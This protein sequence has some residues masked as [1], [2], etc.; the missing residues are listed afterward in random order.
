MFGLTCVSARL[1]GIQSWRSMTT[2]SNKQGTLQIAGSA[3]LDRR[4]S[5][6]QFPPRTTRYFIS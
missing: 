1:K 3:G 2:F 4:A 5:G 6:G